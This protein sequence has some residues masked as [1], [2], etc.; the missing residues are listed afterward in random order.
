MSF[1]LT[2]EHVHSLVDPTAEGD[3]SK[4]LGAIDP[5]VHWIVVDPTFDP[6]SLAGTYVRHP[7][8]FS[9]IRK[10]LTKSTSHQNLQTWQDIIG[11]QLAKLVVGPL[12]M[13]V[14]ELDVIGNK[15]IMES[16]GDAVQA[17]G[18]PYRNR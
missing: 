11:A 5:S 18:K 6:S 4:F 16:T 8:P 15:A 9:I 2:K 12:K 1:T 13:S 7:F 14:Y 17:N 10:S 3:W